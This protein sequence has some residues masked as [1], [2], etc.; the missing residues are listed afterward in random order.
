MAKIR[1]VIQYNGHNKPYLVAEAELSPE[2]VN[3][4]KTRCLISDDVTMNLDTWVYWYQ[5]GF[6]PKPVHLNCVNDLKGKLTHKD[7]A[8]YVNSNDVMEWCF[9]LNVKEILNVS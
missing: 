7:A 6:P 1:H 3:S 5:G 8:N 4:I 2:E 9:E